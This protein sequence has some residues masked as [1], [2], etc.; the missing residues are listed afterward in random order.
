M[1]MRFV[2]LLDEDYQITDFFQTRM[3]AIYEKKEDWDFVNYIKIPHDS[4]TLRPHI[5]KRV[6]VI[7]SYM[8]ENNSTMLLGGTIVGLPY[9]MF[10][11]NG[12]NM[13]EIDYISQTVF[14]SI[15]EDFY[16]E[17]K[18]EIIEEVPPYPIA[19]NEEGVYFLNF[20]KA[21]GFHP[22]S[23]SKKMLLPFL[24]KGSF[25]CLSILCS[26]I[27]PWLETYAAQHNMKMNAQKEYGRYVIIIVPEAM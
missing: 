9:Y 12:V 11:A 24:D 23:S 26:H 21:I 14:Q 17:H 13:C 19:T 6:D 16:E 22:E 7:C 2:V 3:L 27:M 15:Y 1:F 4:G 8:K 20:D 10:H 25:R 18:E 5:T